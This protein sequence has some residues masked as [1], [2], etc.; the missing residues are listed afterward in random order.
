MIEAIEVQVISKLLTCDDEY[1]VDTLLSYD[2]TYFSGYLREFEYIAKHKQKY[3]SVP[4]TFDFLAQFPDFSL[5][6]VPEPL[7]YLQERLREYKKHLIL[8]ETFNKIKDL[9]EGEV[10]DT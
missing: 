3:G 1:V 7:E 5:V 4:G 2:R 6:D 8:L 10:N 9:G